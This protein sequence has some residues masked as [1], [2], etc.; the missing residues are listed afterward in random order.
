MDGEVTPIMGDLFC[1][2]YITYIIFCLKHYVRYRG[3]FDLWNRGRIV[4][5][6]LLYK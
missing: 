6:L 5:I 4:N 1:I 3:Y 2:I